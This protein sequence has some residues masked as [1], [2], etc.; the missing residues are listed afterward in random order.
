MAS[1]P[2]IGRI[3]MSVLGKVLKL[4]IEGDTKDTFRTLSLYVKDCNT[5]YCIGSQLI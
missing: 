1:I 3:F 4:H 5:R 2:L